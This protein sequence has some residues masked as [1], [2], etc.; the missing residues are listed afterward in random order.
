MGYA[1]IVGDACFEGSK[2]DTYMRVWA[3]DEAHD[4]APT[5]P[6]D[7]M[8]GNGNSRSPSYTGWSEFCRDTGLYGM[9]FGKDG[10]RNPYMEADP[11]C[12]RE[13]PIMAEHPGYAMIND[14][15]VI[16]IRAALDLHIAKHGQ[17]EPGFRGW[18][19]REEDAPS[20]AM[21]CAQRARLIWLHYWCD[22]AVKNCEW[23]VIA[24]S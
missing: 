6:N 24:N 3:K 2:E 15:D 14:Q 11:N 22:W 12:H 20:D 4:A 10:R 19:E 18:M 13:T 9:F 17:V 8:T 21:A 1:I 23:P 7:E 5:F 16:A